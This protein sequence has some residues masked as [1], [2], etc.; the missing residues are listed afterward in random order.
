MRTLPLVVMAVALGTSVSPASCQE[1][2]GVALDEAT[3]VAPAQ[4]PVQDDAPPDASAR[5]GFGQVMALLTGLLEDAAQREAS[6]GTQGVALDNPAVVVSVTPVQGADS[7]V[8]RDGSPARDDDRRADDQRD[9]PRRDAANA[10]LAGQSNH[11][12]DATPR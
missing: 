4:A 5:S 2:E 9:A 8:R 10:R 12:P 6:G 1:T 7:F 11:A 3:H